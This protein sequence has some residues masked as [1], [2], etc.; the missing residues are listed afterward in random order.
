[1]TPKLLPLADQVAA[2]I[3]RRQAFAL[4]ERP[5]VTCGDTV[6]TYGEAHAR[7]N[8]VANAFLALG[9]SR[10]TRVG[11]LLRNRLE[12]LDLWFGLSRIGAIQLP[13]NTEYKRAQILHVLKRAPV[14][15]VVVQEDLLDELLPA[16]EELPEV[17]TLVVL[18]NADAARRRAKMTVCS[19]GESLESATGDDPDCDSVMG[20][21]V[22]AVMNTSGTTGPSKG[23][24]LSHAQQHVLGRNIAADIGLSGSDV[25]YNFFPLFHNTA[26][27]MITLP[28]LLAG[29]KMVLVEKFSATRFWQ[30]VREH[31]CTAFY[32][33]GEILRILL[34][35]TS[36]EDGRG[37]SLRVGWGIGASA[38]DF[39]D[40]QTR[41]GV[42]LRSGYGSTEAN[43][44]VYLPHESPDPASVGRVI[45]GFELR[46]ADEHD[47]PVPSGTMGE[48]LVRSSEPCA[49]ML[50]YDGD[51]DATL[52]A[53]RD[54]WF[55][56]GDAGYLDDAGN[57]YFMGR[58]RDVIRV[59]GENVSAFE[60]EEVISQA[61]G[62]LEVAA[63]AV[64]AELGG[65]EVKVV[66]VARAGAKVDPL[67][68][69]AH[70]TARLPRFAI[71]RYVEVVD[72]LPKTETNKVRKNVLRATPFTSATW[73][74]MGTASSA[75]QPTRESDRKMG[76][77]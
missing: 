33:I 17:R 66:V 47:G 10:G 67:A 77:N 3:L 72:A 46:I 26:Q 30:D 20:S 60:V 73:D 32:Y 9:A 36:V 63:V 59:R 28:V 45:P 38:K 34:K 69:I 12:Y 64:P 51:A 76:A 48:I 49:I 52:A 53:W 31:R 23:V 24:R 2:H 65:D 62:V 27:A 13:I 7:A 15:L 37:T 19:Y 61:D 43:V 14:P 74:R 50:G 4:G 57:L 25:Y 5:F 22:G 39:T 56:T 18:G 55:H 54:L 68:L 42:T 41:Y 71:P 40:F 29:A 35:S 6:V 8:R 1:M 58:L 11:V 70:A 16:L 21:D 75:A 44:P